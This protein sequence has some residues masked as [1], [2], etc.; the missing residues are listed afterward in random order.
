[1]SN[2]QL[3]TERRDGKGSGA[4]RR[5]RRADKVPA[6]IYGGG[7]DPLMI[8]VAHNALMYAHEQ[9]QLSGLFR[10]NAGG[11]TASVILRDLQMHPYKPRIM[12][13]DFQ[14]VRATETIRI[15]VA[16]HVSGEDICPGVKTNGG[17]LT[18]DLV[19]LEIE[20]RAD[21]IP[22][23]IEVDASQLDIGDSIHLTDIVMPEGT[24]L[25]DL[26]EFDKLDEDEQLAANHI[27]VSV[28]PPAKE[29]TDEE[30]EAEEIEMVEPEA[31]EED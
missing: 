19:Q 9:R 18:H 5:L 15:D 3:T 6:V 2:F 20:C 26:M 24:I 29:E 10:V 4:S 22:E 13:A 31:P 8:A 25:V 1:M 17:I 28:Q 12:H 14:R 11:E 30:E 16:I 21:A 7:A 27:V 23:Y